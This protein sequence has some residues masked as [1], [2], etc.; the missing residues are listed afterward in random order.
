MFAGSLGCPA[1]GSGGAGSASDGAALLLSPLV[2]GAS[3]DAIVLL[4]LEGAGP[5]V[6]SMCGDR[7]GTAEV[8]TRSANATGR[9]CPA[10][11]RAQPSTPARI[12]VLHV[13]VYTRMY[14]PQRARF[15]EE[16]AGCCGSDPEFTWG[17][18]SHLQR[19]PSPRIFEQSG[20]NRSLKDRGSSRVAGSLNGGEAPA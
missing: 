2:L 3:A 7:T 9:L 16:I 11:P 12:Q 5:A 15:E 6:A 18:F 8:R 20:T 14:L 4:P 13:G 1:V 19:A 10:A 17:T